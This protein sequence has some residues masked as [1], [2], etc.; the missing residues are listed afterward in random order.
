MGDI[1]NILAIE[2]TPEHV[3]DVRA[4]LG[5]RGAVVSTY[6][7]FITLVAS[8]PKLVLSDLYFPTGYEN[9]SDLHK[10][11]K[12]GALAVLDD[13]IE[14]ERGN[15]NPIAVAVNQVVSVGV[16]GKTP[17]EVVKNLKLDPPSLR[18]Q[19][20]HSVKDDQRLKGYEKLREAMAK[21]ENL[22]P[23]GM[24]VYQ[25]CQAQGIP[26]VIVTDAYHHGTEF[27]P[28]V[29]KVGNYFDQLVDGKKQ[30]KAALD[31]KE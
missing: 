31:S 22:L 25:H 24:F 28:F 26:A 4:L 10:K 5:N 15:G 19:V 1:S 2:D 12:D 17:E 27:Q 14:R 23:L 13:Y 9:E 11:L 8:K 16:L 29:A 18:S 7:D 6:K 30:W 20:E 3:E 21:D